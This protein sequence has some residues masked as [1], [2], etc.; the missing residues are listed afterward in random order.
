MARRVDVAAGL[1]RAAELGYGSDHD[2]ENADPRQPGS[3]AKTA[4][5]DAALLLSGTE[6]RHP[7]LRK[8][9]A[10]ARL[11]L[12]AAIIAMDQAKATGGSLQAQVA[13]ENTLMAYGNALANLIRGD[14]P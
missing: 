12:V 8:A 11:D 7:G 3:A 9:E 13:V 1:T 6:E 2:H 10:R 5:L 4:L 14:Q